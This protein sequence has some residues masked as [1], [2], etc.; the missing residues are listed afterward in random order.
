MA[1]EDQNDVIEIVDPIDDPQNYLNR[2]LSMLQFFRR[3]LFEAQ[4]TDNPLLERVQFLGIIGSILDEFFM[5]RV[6]SLTMDQETNHDHFYFEGMPPLVQ[7]QEIRKQANHLFKDAQD[8]FFKELTPLLEA[9]GIHVYS[10][11]QLG[12]SQKSR[13]DDYFQEVIFP[14]LTPLGFDPGHPF[15]YI[16]NLSYNLAIL[17]EDQ[18]AIRHF[19]R[20]K[21]PGSLPYFLPVHKAA[22]DPS[23]RAKHAKKHAFVRIIDVIMANLPALFPGLKVIEAHPFQ[24][25]RNA[26]IELQGLEVMD[27]LEVMEESVRRRRFGAVVQLM[28][29]KSMPDHILKILVDNL[30]VEPQFIYSYENPVVLRY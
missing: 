26:E 1:N 22:Y 28:V 6:G 19:V 20:L 30:N 12:K 10:Y 16:S 13:V 17:V 24:V 5:V 4:S 8:C 21:V 25:V 29:G 15:P 18:Y 9:E 14:V 3:V 11:D 27:L 23:P 2:E 7:L